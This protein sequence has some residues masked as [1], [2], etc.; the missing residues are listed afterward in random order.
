LPRQASLGTHTQGKITGVSAG[1]LEEV[2][3]DYYKTEDFVPAFEA[4]YP[5]EEKR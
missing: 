5:G 2:T 4:A 3:V 1:V